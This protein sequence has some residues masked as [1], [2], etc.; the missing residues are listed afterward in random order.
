MRWY[1][2]CPLLLWLFC[3]DTITN[4]LCSC[5]SFSFLSPP[6]TPC[7][8]V[9]RHRD[10]MR[11]RR[12]G[13]VVMAPWRTRLRCDPQLWP[14]CRCH[15]AM[16]SGPRHVPTLVHT[17]LVCVCLWVPMGAYG[18][19]CL[20]LFCLVPRRRAET[21]S[22]DDEVSHKPHVMVPTGSSSLLFHI[23]SV[24]SSGQENNK[25]VFQF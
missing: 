21:F 9:S 7:V 20:S 13:S 14:W 12:R 1:V 5:I 11:S 16:V 18:C 6:F 3:A 17:V 15:D 24:F 25:F 23:S 4:L 10:M 19:L 22:P 8:C 2:V